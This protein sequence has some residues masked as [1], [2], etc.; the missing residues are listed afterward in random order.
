MC[1]VTDE[2]VLNAMMALD[3]LRL[4]VYEAEDRCDGSLMTP[5]SANYAV[6]THLP[7]QTAHTS[8][9]APPLIISTRY[10]LNGT[11][12]YEPSPDDSH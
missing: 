11:T 7:T 9:V 8:P 3:L 12:I 1:A 4:R 6:M 5:H 2:R 10:S